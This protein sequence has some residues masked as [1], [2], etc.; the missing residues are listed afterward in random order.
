MI[1]TERNTGECRIYAG[2]MEGTHGDGF[3]AAVVVCL[4]PA[5]GRPARE[6]HRDESLACGHRWRTHE[7]AVAYALLKGQEAADR[8]R[9]ANRSLSLQ[10]AA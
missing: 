3:I 2:A 10:Q 7:S 6:I 4:L 9:G 8:V 1:L 5:A